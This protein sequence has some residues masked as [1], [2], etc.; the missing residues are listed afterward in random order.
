GL[1]GERHRSDANAVS[2]V[3]GIETRLI[4]VEDLSVK[5]SIE[6]CG[7][8]SIQIQKQDSQPTA[9]PC[10]IDEIAMKPNN[11]IGL[12]RLG[13]SD[14]FPALAVQFN[15]RVQ[16]DLRVRLRLRA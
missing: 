12:E 6:R 10:E 11:P 8:R 1:Y 14:F 7:G 13:G 5:Q 2:A 15:D 4:K 16:R 3:D 9:L